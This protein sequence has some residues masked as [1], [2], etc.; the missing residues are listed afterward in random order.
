[1]YLDPVI[2]LCK[3]CAIDSKRAN[4]VEASQERRAERR[5]IP[6][7]RFARSYSQQSRLM[8]PPLSIPTCIHFLLRSLFKFVGCTQCSFDEKL[9]TYKHAPC[10][11]HLSFLTKMPSWCLEVFRSRLGC[12]NMIC[13]KMCERARPPLTNNK[14]V[15][16]LHRKRNQRNNRLQRT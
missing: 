16:L 7:P 1:M 10:E 4:K 15:L 3:N 13:I 8:S 14:C 6:A 11:R 5:G 12:V 9:Y 2:A